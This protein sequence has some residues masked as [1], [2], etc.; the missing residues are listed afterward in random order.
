MIRGRGKKRQIIK[1]RE[2]P[3]IILP[4]TYTVQGNKQKSY[5][6][7]FKHNYYNINT[8]TSQNE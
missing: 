2:I 1:I 5:K 7:E 6:N 8:L 3:A 4:L